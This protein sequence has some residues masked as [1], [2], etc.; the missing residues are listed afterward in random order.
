[1]LSTTAAT[2]RELTDRITA[3]DHTSTLNHVHY[4]TQIRQIT[5]QQTAQAVQ[6][7]QINH[8]HAAAAILQEHLRVAATQRDHHHAAALIALLPAIPEAHGHH[9]Q[10]LTQLQAAVTAVEVL[11]V[12]VAALVAREAVPVAAH[13]V[14]VEDN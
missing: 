1:M 12:R 5:T 10:A 11:P 9:L 8:L 3:Q 13:Q 6:V 7:I 2:H 14:A 4:K